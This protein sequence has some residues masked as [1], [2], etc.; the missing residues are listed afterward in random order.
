M[1]EINFFVSSNYT[2]D[3]NLHALN[4]TFFNRIIF[5]Y[6]VNGSINRNQFKFPSL[7]GGFCN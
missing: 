6:T 4:P 3:Y 5:V 1:H 2:G 7:R